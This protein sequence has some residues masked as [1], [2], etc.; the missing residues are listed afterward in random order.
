MQQSRWHRR[1]LLINQKRSYS[2]SIFQCFRVL[3]HASRS[4]LRTS[5]DVRRLLLI[6][7]RRFSNRGRGKREGTKEYFRISQLTNKSTPTVTDTSHGLHM[8]ESQDD[9]DNI[10]MYIYIHMYMSMYIS[11][12]IY[13]HTHMNAY[14]YIH[15]C[16]YIFMCVCMYNL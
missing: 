6:L 16:V 12:D 2:Q 7:V 3:S 9:S 4:A 11:M 10:H 13:I 1:P 15:I 8:P 5:S 14:M